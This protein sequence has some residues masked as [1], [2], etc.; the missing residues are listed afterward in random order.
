MCSQVMAGAPAQGD[1]PA[2][3]ERRRLAQEMVLA[4]DI[5]MIG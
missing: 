2:L 4:E 5:V 1:S 3:T